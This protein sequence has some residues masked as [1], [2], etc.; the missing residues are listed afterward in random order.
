M[1]YFNPFFQ[2]EFSCEFTCFWHIET[3]KLLPLTWTP[4]FV[5]TPL[6]MT[7]LGS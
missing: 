1:S 2:V 4:A 3:E 7:G 5:V 6:S